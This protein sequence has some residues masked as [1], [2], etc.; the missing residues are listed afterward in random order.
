MKALKI[1]HQHLKYWLSLAGV[2]VFAIAYA[3]FPNHARTKFFAPSASQ[4][5]IEP[6]PHFDSHF[7]SSSLD[8][9]VHAASVTRLE[10]GALRAVWFGGTREGA[11]DV[12]IYSALF[13]PGS[14][15]WTAN[16]VLVDR[17][18]TEQAVGRT[19][20]K[21]GNPVIGTAPDGRLW[22]FYVSVSV[23][24]WAGSA[25][26]FMVSSDEG[27]TWSQPKRLITT[28]FFNISTL[29]RGQPIFHRDGTIGLPVYH[30]FL[31]KFPEYLRLDQHGRV[32]DKTRMDYG[33]DSLQPSTVVLSETDA[34]SLLRYAG[35]PPRRVLVSETSETG[36]SWSQPR[37]AP[38]VNPNSGLTAVRYSDDEIL[39]ALNDLEQGRH[40]LTLY[41]ADNDLRNWQRVKVL[42]QSPASTGKLVPEDIYRKLVSIDFARSDD[43]AHPDL[44][45]AY[46][47]ELDERMCDTG[48]CEFAYAYPYLI[49]GASNRFDLIYTWNKSMIKHVVF[50]KAWLEQ[51]R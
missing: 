32:I 43:D 40:R 31:G 22:V 24:G 1:N 15:E 33:R 13:D 27:E 16:K 6:A 19:I 37:M 41:L 10:R 7:V 34:I 42:E 45:S 35:D 29:V 20:R 3:Y 4:A 9:Y 30:E 21:L 47:A 11:R 38:I 8:Q 28:P 36:E 14:N 39:I 49:K 51:Y 46:L 25:I 5:A 48:G 18:M 12:K 17:A 23:G 50:N 44:L 26:N 2:V